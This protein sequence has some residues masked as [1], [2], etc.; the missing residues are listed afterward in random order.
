M[1]E[2]NT[3]DLINAVVAQRD[4]AINGLAQVTAEKSALKRHIAELE[5]KLKEFEEKKE[6]SV[7]DMKE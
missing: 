6:D 2:V 3:Q 5:E 7:L 1:S 4:N